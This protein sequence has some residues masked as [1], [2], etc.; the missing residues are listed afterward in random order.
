MNET[1]K[2]ILAFLGFTHSR[3]EIGKKGYS[4]VSP[5]VVSVFMKSP[6]HTHKFFFFVTLAS[7]LTASQGF[8]DLH[9]EW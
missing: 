6:T 8:A 7:V 5:F 2:N 9:G 4:Y 1:D 3:K